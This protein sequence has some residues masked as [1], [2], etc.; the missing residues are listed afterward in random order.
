MSGQ[1]LTTPEKS[2]R[3][4]TLILL[5]ALVMAGLIVLSALSLTGVFRLGRPEASSVATASRIDASKKPVEPTARFDPGDLRIYC[6]A[7]VRAFEDTIVEARWL[8]GKQLVRSFA[9]PFSRL[10]GISAGRLF[11]STADVAFFIERPQGGWTPGTYVV[12]VRLDGRTAGS[13]DFAVTGGQGEEEGP[14]QNTYREPDGSFTVSYPADWSVADPASLGDA[15]AGF[16]SPGSG[17]FP[18]RFVVLLTEYESAEPEYL[19]GMLALPAGEQGFAAYSLGEARG[20]R[21]TYNWVF[22]T[23]GGPVE[24]KSTQVVMPGGKGVYALNCHSLASEFD[25]NAPAFNAIINSFRVQ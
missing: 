10:T 17:D 9:R 19:N 21:R 5:S 4:I 16:I 18:A 7:R 8:K 2:G 22:A 15:L 12:Q 24:L 1:P 11:P 3:R 20:A 23:E 13:A 14:Q 25:D 6:T